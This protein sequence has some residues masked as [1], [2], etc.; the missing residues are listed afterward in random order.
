MCVCDKVVV[1]IVVVVLMGARLLIP[2]H[3]LV[4]KFLWDSR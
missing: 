4:L 1:A 3:H 2:I